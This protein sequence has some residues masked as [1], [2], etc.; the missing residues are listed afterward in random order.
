MN[1]TYH[2]LVGESQCTPPRGSTTASTTA[3]VRARPSWR[4][5]APGTRREETGEGCV[6]F[7]AIVGLLTR[8]TLHVNAYIRSYENRLFVGAVGLEPTS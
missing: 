4:T 3:T 7:F 2:S 6:F 1:P 5:R 8:F